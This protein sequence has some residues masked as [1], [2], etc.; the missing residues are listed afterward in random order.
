MQ[1][2]Y[3]FTIA[4]ALEA[5]AA[6]ANADAYADGIDIDDNESLPN[7]QPYAQIEV[8]SSGN[9]EHAAMKFYACNKCNRTF[10]HLKSL[11]R[12]SMLHIGLF[13]STL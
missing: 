4:E 11:K 5:A 10:S 8:N 7:Y 12:H 9:N 1:N 3:E 13:T 2:N 6:A